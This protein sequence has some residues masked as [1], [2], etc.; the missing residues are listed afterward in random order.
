DP[1]RRSRRQSGRGTAQA[2]RISGTFEGIEGYGE[3]G[4]DLS[5]HSTDHVPGIVVCDADIRRAA[6]FRNVRKR[7][8]SV[9]GADANRRR[10][11]RISARLLVAVADCRARYLRVHELSTDRSGYPKGLGRAFFDHALVRPYRLEHG[12]G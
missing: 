4:A 12:N 6:I 7:G 9:A 3:Y 5:G 1:G 11:G 10:I 8:S 2:V